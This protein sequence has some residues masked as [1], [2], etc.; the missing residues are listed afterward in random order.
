MYTVTEVNSDVIDIVATGEYD[1]STIATSFIELLDNYIDIIPG[2]D[3][4]RVKVDKNMELAVLISKPKILTEQ[5][6]SGVAI[7]PNTSLKSKIDFTTN[8]LDLDLI[9]KKIKI[10]DIV[11]DTNKLMVYTHH[12]KLITD[13]SID[14]VILKDSTPNDSIV[15]GINNFSISSRIGNDSIIYGVFW[16]NWNQ[17]TR[18]SGEIE[19]YIARNNDSTLFNFGRAD[20]FIN[21]LM[22]DI[23]T[24]NLIL[25][26]DDRVYFS[27]F[28][29][30]AGKSKFKLIGTVPRTENDSLVA[31]FED[32]NLSNFDLITIPMNLDLDGQ[33]NGELKLSII[34]DNP[35]LFPTLT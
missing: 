8:K 23:D 11:L 34:K 16:K 12:G 3:S 31:Q 22:W 14:N 19:G 29:I 5:F 25:M 4:T 1:L 18:N 21:G 20:V 17:A 10:N 9:S 26:Y 15:L 13:F 2:V 24:N 35:T 28:F 32:W 33:I 30:N 27:D 7:A 6:F